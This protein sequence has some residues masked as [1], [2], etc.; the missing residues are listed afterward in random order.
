MATWVVGPQIK[1]RYVLAFFQKLAS[2][3]VR[4]VLGRMLVEERHERAVSDEGRDAVGFIVLRHVFEIVVRRRMAEGLAGGER[5]A[6]DASLIK[7][8]ANRESGVQGAEKLDPVRSRRA[9]RE[10]LA[11]LDDEAL[12][13]ARPV[14]Y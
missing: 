4:L 14:R 13:A 10:Y 3:E 2:C 12:G 8:E 9:V 5:F 7:A 11:V 6:V 1:R